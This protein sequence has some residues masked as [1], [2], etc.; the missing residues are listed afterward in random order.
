[1]IRVGFLN[2]VTAIHLFERRSLLT[3]RVI[4]YILIFSTDALKRLKNFDSSGESAVLRVSAEKI[5]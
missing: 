1:M 5:F 3:M 4:I 2:F